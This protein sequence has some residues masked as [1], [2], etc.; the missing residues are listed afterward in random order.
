MLLKNRELRTTAPRYKVNT[1][2]PQSFL[3]VTLERLAG[4]KAHKHV[5]G[6]GITWSRYQ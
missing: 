3:T 6:S 5:P 4:H 1:G 2:Y